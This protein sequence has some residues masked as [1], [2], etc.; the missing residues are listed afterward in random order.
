MGL[1]QFANSLENILGNPHINRR[2]GI[3]RHLHWQYLKAFDRFPVELDIS[4]SRIVAAHKRCGVS[5]LIY[6]QGLYNY[7]NMRLLQ[8]LLKTGAVFSILAPTSVRSP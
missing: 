7:N 3:I 8:M 2:E 1:R 5:A 4:H 6:S